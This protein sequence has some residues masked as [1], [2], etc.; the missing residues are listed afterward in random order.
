MFRSNAVRSCVEL[1]DLELIPFYDVWERF[2][3][4]H[5]PFRPKP[6]PQRGEECGRDEA[7]PNWDLD[8]PGSCVHLEDYSQHL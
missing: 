6:C 5:T 1:L 7:C 2:C 3:S 4:L 8:A